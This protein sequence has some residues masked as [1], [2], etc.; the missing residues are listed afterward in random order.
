MVEDSA[1][2]AILD[3]GATVNFAKRMTEWKDFGNLA[4]EIR[5]E[6]R[7]MQQG[8]QML[9]TMFGDELRTCKEAIRS[10]AAQREETCTQLERSFNEALEEEAERRQSVESRLDARV[11]ALHAN[12]AARFKEELS[13]T[14]DDLHAALAERSITRDDSKATQQSLSMS[15][16]EERPEQE[17][18]ERLG[19]AVEGEAAARRALESRLQGQLERLASDL[20]EAL[21]H[22]SQR[23]P[24]IAAGRGHRSRH[25]REEQPQHGRTAPHAA[26]AKNTTDSKGAGGTGNNS[27]DELSSMLPVFLKDLISWDNAEDEGKKREDCAPDPAAWQASR[28]QQQAE[29]MQTRPIPRTEKSLA[30]SRSSE[31]ARR[32]EQKDKPSDAVDGLEVKAIHDAVSE[33]HGALKDGLRRE[34]EAR[35]EAF[36]VL[37]APP[38]LGTIMSEQDMLFKA[39]AN[40]D[41]K[42]GVIQ[43]DLHLTVQ[44]M[45]QQSAEIITELRASKGQEAF[46]AASKVLSIPGKPAASSDKPALGRE[47]PLKGW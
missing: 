2:G 40:L 31:P 5:H 41:S 6:F 8:L 46:Q 1:A 33:L 9:E 19:E 15:S 45:S 20:E 10:E 34:A 44:Q 32:Q 22:S 30:Q 24:D 3:L 36:A 16:L 39:V 27:G 47:K 25:S 18:L 26:G 43:R 38:Q 17:L 12:I 23:S 37:Q 13:D 35:T 42:I 11:G 14:L 7:A 21:P 4:D 28:P 29:L